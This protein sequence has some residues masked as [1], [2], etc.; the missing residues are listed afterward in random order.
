MLALTEGWSQFIVLAGA[1]VIGAIVLGIGRA[2]MGLVRTRQTKQREDEAAEQNLSQY[3]F[4]QPRNERTGTPATIGWTTT[5]DLTLKE[6]RLAQEHTNKVVNQ[7]LY[8]I[9]PN[10]GKNFRGLVERGVDAASAEVA[11][12]HKN[13]ED[14]R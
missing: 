1:G 4:D 14:A 10:G 2:L 6:L 9:T 5:V 11:R 3:F 13:E 8:E 12:V 7:I